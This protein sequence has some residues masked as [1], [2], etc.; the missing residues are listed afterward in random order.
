MIDQLSSHNLN[1]FIVLADCGGWLGWTSFNSWE[2]TGEPDEDLNP[3]YVA[4]RT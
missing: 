3:D 4:V 2:L 1:E